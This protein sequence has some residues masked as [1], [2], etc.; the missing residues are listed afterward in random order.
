MPREFVEIQKESA[1][2]ANH[3]D[4]DDVKARDA[5]DQYMRSIRSA[6]L[7]SQDETA[8]LS[9]Q[10]HTNESAFRDAVYAMTSAVD[11]V[12]AQWNARLHEGRVT[13][14]M[15]SAFR[16]GGDRDWSVHID[17]QLAQASRLREARPR[18]TLD[19]RLVPIL[20]EAALSFE[21]RSKWPRSRPSSRAN[22]PGSPSG[23]APRPPS[24][25]RATM[26][27]AASFST[28]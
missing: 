12:L 1:S 4:E 5:L 13:G 27:A 15:A 24:S 19:P 8:E 6:P 17:A 2:I 10:I 3:A 25:P 23:Y 28:T 11:W 7:L 26:P 14:V 16:E 18:A 20:A 21:V 22:A 9:R